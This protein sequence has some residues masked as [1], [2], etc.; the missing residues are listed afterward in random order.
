[1]NAKTVTPFI[2]KTPVEAFFL[3]NYLMIKFVEMC[4]NK[5]ILSVRKGNL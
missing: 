4:Y 5:F 3:S 1:M 2:N